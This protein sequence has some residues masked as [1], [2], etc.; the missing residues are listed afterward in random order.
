LVILSVLL[1]I[2]F[3]FAYLVENGWICPSSLFFRFNVCLA[4]AVPHQMLNRAPIALAK[5][6]KAF[7]SAFAAQMTLRSFSDISRG[8]SMTAT[9]ARAATA[10]SL[11]RS[12]AAAA[13]APAA[14]AVSSLSALSPSHF[15]PAAVV[16]PV[17]APAPAPVTLETLTAMSFTAVGASPA[18]P[19][20]GEHTSSSSSSSSSSSD[21]KSGSSGEGQGSGSRARFTTQSLVNSARL[22]LL[23]AAGYA[24]LA[25]PEDVTAAEDA[26][27]HLSGTAPSFSLFGC[28]FYNVNGR[29]YIT[30]AGK[31]IRI[32]TTSLIIAANTAVFLLWKVPRFEPFL[33]AHF[34]TSWNHVMVG[35][36][37]HTLVTSAF[38]HSTFMHFL[39]NNFAL[40]SLGRFYDDYWSPSRYLSV[41]FGAAA[42]SS[43]AQIFGGAGMAYLLARRGASDLAVRFMAP[44]LGASGAL[45]ALISHT[46]LLSPHAQFRL[47]FMIEL[48][49]R[50]LLPIL[51]AFDLGG[52]V[53]TAL[54]TFASP[55]GHMAH[56]GGYLSG[57]AVYKMFPP[58]TQQ[59]VKPRW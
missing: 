39:F 28:N 8:S 43:L 3:G 12:S 38:S 32:G 49:A 6:S 35:H 23:G 52:V 21:S 1:K 45:G 41:W 27:V 24:M 22:A 31:V 40:F 7:A 56:L 19:T 44:M 42:V 37:W 9:A 48:S 29:F 14:A 26:Y 46:C 57:M 11:I 10:G 58:Q 47:F 30:F 53:G 16:A 15:V 20:A 25:A 36:R 54:G 33:K 50:Q 51:F 4:V 55:F 17:A 59:K 18:A 5:G 34:L 13:P 2:N